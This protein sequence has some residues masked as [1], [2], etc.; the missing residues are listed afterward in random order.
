MEANEILKQAKEMITA[1]GEAI[2]GIAD[3]RRGIIK[4]RLWG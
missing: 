1:E 2:I 4:N 3:E